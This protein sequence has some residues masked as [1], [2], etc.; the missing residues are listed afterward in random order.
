M[1]EGS[2]PVPLELRCKKP[3]DWGIQGITRK[4]PLE[5]LEELENY[6]IKMP[7]EFPPGGGAEHGATRHGSGVTL[8][9]PHNGCVKGR[10]L[11][12]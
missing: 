11:L 4:G 1:Q 2:R 6:V 3:R 7:E 8:R 5:L 10:T 12:Q 9:A